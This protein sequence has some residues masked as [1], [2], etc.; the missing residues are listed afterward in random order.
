MSSTLFQK[1]SNLNVFLPILYVVWS[2]AVLTPTEVRAINDLIDKQGWLT[3]D[4]V[5]Y[6]KSRLDP[7]SPPTPDELRGWLNEIRQAT[8]D[9]TPEAHV[10]LVD[11]G[12]RLAELKGDSEAAKALAPENVTFPGIQYETT[13]FGND[14]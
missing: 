10:R 5:K 3:P 11:I 1:N 6:L 2:D 8:G 4:E 7:K 12:I 14:N 9:I 13:E